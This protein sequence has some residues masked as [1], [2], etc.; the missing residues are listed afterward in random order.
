MEALRFAA[1][2]GRVLRV[3]G[4]GGG[5][6][7]VPRQAQQAAPPAL[8]RAPDGRWPQTGVD[9]SADQASAVTAPLPGRLTRIV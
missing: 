7:L 6:N 1:L 9:T 3:P 8:V 2:E 4:E 5:A